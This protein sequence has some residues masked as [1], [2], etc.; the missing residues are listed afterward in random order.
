MKVDAN[1]LGIVLG[2]FMVAWHTVWSALVAIGWAQP[3]IDFVFWMHFMAPA[4]H[5]VGFDP[6]R[7]GVLI[8]VTGIFGYVAGLV[9]GLLWNAVHRS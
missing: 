7:A 6:L 2:L 5:V 9:A 8:L 3:L 4:F 1:R